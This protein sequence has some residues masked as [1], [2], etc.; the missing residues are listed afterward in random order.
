MTVS[1]PEPPAGRGALDSSTLGL[2]GQAGAVRGV[3]SAPVGPYRLV[4]KRV[5]DVG[6]TLAGLPI[7]LPLVAVL[8]AVVALE[9]GKPFYRQVRVGK[10][11]KPFLMWK[12]RSMVPD[13]DARMADYLAANPAARAEWDSTQKLRDDPRITRFGGFLRRASLDELPQLW[14][15]L[16]GD[17]SLVGPRPMLINQQP[18]YPGQA[19]YA[20]R[21]GV[22]G[23][24]QTAGRNRTTFEVRADY[25]TAYEANVT[26][27]ADLEILLRTLGVVV[28]GTGC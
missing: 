25:D 2:G 8:A 19:Y 11:G 27:K 28:R 20:L 13:A 15:V 22:T 16:R 1:F 23:Y 14:N 7:V 6:A 18:I 17:M 9:G 12:L 10:G 24:W 3:S 21:P 5:L 4:F 26:L